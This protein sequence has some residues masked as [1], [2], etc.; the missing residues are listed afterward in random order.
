MRKLA[1]LFY[2]I[3]HLFFTQAQPVSQVEKQ[4]FFHSSK[5]HS[6]CFV[7]FE[8][9]F[10]AMLKQPSAIMGVNLNWLINHKIYIGGKYQVQSLP[11]YVEKYVFSTDFSRI[12]LKHQSASLNIGYI[13]FDDKTFSLNP[14]LSAGWSQIVY[15]VNFGKTIRKNYGL[16]ILGIN[17][18]WNAHKN[19]R[20]GAGVGGRMLLG[21]RIDDLKAIQMSGLFGQLFLR[22]GTF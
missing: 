12:P 1:L 17:G 8:G 21:S 11:L 3:G 13:F 4:S 19:V 22:V 9:Q 5:F 10:S 18:I 15:D 20:V 7:Q 16:A 6:A 2:L 14:E